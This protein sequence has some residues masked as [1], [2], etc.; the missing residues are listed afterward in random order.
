MASKIQKSSQ[1]GLWV[2]LRREKS[3]R[4]TVIK[5][6]EVKTQ[7]TASTVEPRFW[8]PPGGT[9]RVD[10]CDIVRELGRK[11]ACAARQLGRRTTGKREMFDREKTLGS[12]HGSAVNWNE[13]FVLTL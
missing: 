11:A 8:S 9:G 10:D 1:P 12:W 4:K 6:I 7:V 2:N 3:R 5:A 13:A